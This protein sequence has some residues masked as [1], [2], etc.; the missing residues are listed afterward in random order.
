MGI[1]VLVVSIL[2]EV[3]GMAFSYWFG[4]HAF[5]LG[6]MWAATINGLPASFP[7]LH[8]YHLHVT[9]STIGLFWLAGNMSLHLMA[10]IAYV[11]SIAKKRVKMGNPG[12]RE[13][14]AV[15]RACRQLVTAS[16]SASLAPVHHFGWPLTFDYAPGYG[17]AIRFIGRKLTLD[18]GLFKSS[19]L[20]PLL[21]HE[22]GHYNSADVNLR[23]ILGC[24]PPALLVVCGI[25]GLPIGLG[26][27]VTFLFWPWYW[28]QREYAAD[29]F[30][31]RVGQANELIQALDQ[32][33]HPREKRKTIFLREYPYVAERIDRL[34]RYTGMSSV[35]QPSQK[36]QRRAGN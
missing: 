23:E 30:A 28:R 18:E 32:V 10:I 26:P 29:L 21:A 33:V 12:L 6:A 5:G 36:Q 2:L 14:Q 34:M 1:F 24:L 35:P 20:R 4:T 11:R 17:T 3:V 13:V 15:E 27:F 31:A 25:V 22:L 16:P 19:Y 7:G 9:A 8:R